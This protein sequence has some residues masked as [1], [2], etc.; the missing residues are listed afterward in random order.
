MD[1]QNYIATKISY[2]SPHFINCN[3]RYLP[4]VEQFNEFWTKYMYYD[5]SEFPFEINDILRIFMDTYKYKKDIDVDIIMDLIQYY[6]PNVVINDNKSVYKTG[7]VL[8]NK[9]KEIDTFL[10]HQD[11]TDVNELYRIYSESKKGGHNISKQYF[12]EYYNFL[13]ESI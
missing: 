6:Y 2:L 10:L 13:N 5:E 4:Y 8:W 9:K 3:S 7:C 1:V 11:C 12:V